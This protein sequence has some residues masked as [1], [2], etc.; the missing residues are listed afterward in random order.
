MQHP[1]E[2]IDLPS[3]PPSP[4]SLPLSLQERRRHRRCARAIQSRES[5]RLRQMNG[6]LAQHTGRAEHSAHAV[7]GDR[8]GLCPVTATAG[9][10]EAFVRNRECA[11][12]ALVPLSDGDGLPFV[13]DADTRRASV[14]GRHAAGTL[15][16]LFLCGGCATFGRRRLHT[17]SP[18]SVET[19][20]PA[21]RGAVL[22]RRLARPA[23]AQRARRAAR[24][25]R[26]RDD[27]G[28]V[29]VG[30][31]HRRKLGPRT[32]LGWRQRTRGRE[33][34]GQPQCQW[35]GVGSYR[36]R[37][38]SV[39]AVARGATAHQSAARDAAARPALR[40]R[41]ARSLGAST[42]ATQAATTRR[43]TA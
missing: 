32:S 3:E 37:S 25:E 22:W 40:P 28:P 8:R 23:A 27:S 14:G 6:L 35:V 42:R 16:R 20:R 7:A 17:P 34:C 36:E 10:L 2:P 38:K 12:A 30:R 4:L 13:D 11:A 39:V 41:R 31:R 26:A 1:Q 24:G 18:P 19:V 21:A 29:P 43:R 9:A 5:G 33:E 15:W